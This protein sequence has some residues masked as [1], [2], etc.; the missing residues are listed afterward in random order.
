[1]RLAEP[2]PQPSERTSG[3]VSFEHP[4]LPSAQVLEALHEAGIV[5]SQRG[6]FVRLSPH[7]HN[8]DSDIARALDVV[9]SL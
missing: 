8:P 6:P 4:R 9:T 5:A 3:I 2:W 7:Y 1:M